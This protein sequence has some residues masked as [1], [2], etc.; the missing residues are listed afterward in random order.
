MKKDGVVHKNVMNLEVKENYRQR[1]E[2]YKLY[3]SSCSPKAQE[4][5]N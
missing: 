1:Q 4:M 5:P 3:N 2:N